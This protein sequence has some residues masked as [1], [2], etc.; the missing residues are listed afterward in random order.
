ML[1]RLNT[2]TITYNSKLYPVMAQLDFA[3]IADETTQIGDKTPTIDNPSIAMKRFGGMAYASNTLL[4]MKS[5]EFVNA[6]VS[7]FGD[8]L[9]RFIDLYSVAA[10]V[11]GNTDS[12][13]GIVFDANTDGTTVAAS[14]M[15]DI[16][17]KDFVDLKNALGPKQRANAI[18]V[19][20]SVVRDAYGLV[21]DSNGTPVFKDYINNGTIRP[22]GKDFV[23]N[24]YIPSTFDIATSKRT[25]GTDDVLVC[26]N[27]QAV[28]IGFT[29]LMIDGSSEFKFDY[30][31]FAWRAVS[32][33]G[34]KVISKSTTQGVC[35]AY[36][37]ITN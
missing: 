16:T 18:F 2:K 32:E 36:K 4:R 23:E 19:A 25:T 28:Y 37:K 33:I 24:P 21:E 7:Q 20:N 17:V 29:P 30:D 15:A 35:A 34:I 5:P 11:T 14:A 26:L 27:P 12:V 1:S 9:G 22:L 8:A 3:W 31:Q 13:N 10:S 6:L